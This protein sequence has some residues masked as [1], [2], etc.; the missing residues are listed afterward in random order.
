MGLDFR[1]TPNSSCKGRCP[2]PQGVLKSVFVNDLSPST[3][4][5]TKDSTFFHSCW[6]DYKVIIDLPPNAVGTER[7]V[8]P[9]ETHPFVQVQ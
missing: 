3:Y 7:R 8:L 1:F 4:L 5:S 2:W 9:N 6:E